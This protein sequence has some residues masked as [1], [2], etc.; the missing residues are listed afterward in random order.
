[1]EIRR[2]LSIGPGLIAAACVVLAFVTIGLF[3]RMT[4]AIRSI[5]EENVES[6]AA[7]LSVLEVVAGRKA[8]GLDEAQQLRLREVLQRAAA[9]ITVPGEEVIVHEL[10][11]A[12]MSAM[13]GDESAFD[14]LIVAARQLWHINMTVM[15]ER[16]AD[17]AH[18]GTAGA[19]TAV[20]GG[21]VIVL[22]ALV[23]ISRLRRRIA[24]PFEDIVRV[25]TGQG[26]GAVHLRCRPVPGAFEL[27]RLRDQINEV[28]DARDVGASQDVGGDG[29]ELFVLRLALVAALEQSP[30][31]A[32]FIAR[33]GE[34]LAGND[35]GLAVMAS[36]V[37]ASL[38]HAAKELLESRDDFAEVALAHEGATVALTCTALEA[39][40]AAFV[41][42]TDYQPPMAE[43]AGEASAEGAASPEDLVLPRDR[44]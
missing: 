36:D 26:A 24:V 35:G 4:P 6:Q 12:A 27:E 14:R 13:V 19:W 3:V 41:I 11:D 33:D 9:N 28:L 15:E 37:G 23:T 5:I 2:D 18:L 30:R 25:M 31:A 22:I 8:G 1:M 10:E 42:V 16:D 44:L 40:H 34:L 39:H 21:I 17:A 38:R 7:A 20:F 43:G 29:S 32:V